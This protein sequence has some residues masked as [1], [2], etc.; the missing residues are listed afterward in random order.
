MTSIF[1]W[2]L[3]VTLILFA[4]LL[5]YKGIELWYVRTNVDGDGIGVHFLGFEIND[6]VN[7]KNIPAYAIGFF[8]S[9][10]VAV[11]GSAAY[12]KTNIKN[13]KKAG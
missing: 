11:I 1:R 6:R 13:S 5:F 4:V 12:L 9:C 3:P 10:I 2:I 8:I 7:A